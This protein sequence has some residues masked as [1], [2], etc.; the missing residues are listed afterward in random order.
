MYT[1]ACSWRRRLRSLR[2]SNSAGPRRIPG[3]GSLLEWARSTTALH[4][5]RRGSTR[6]TPTDTSRI[7]HSRPLKQHNIALICSGVTRYGVTLGGNWWCHPF[8]LKT[9][10]LFSVIALWK[11][12]TFFSWRLL[13]TPIFPQRLSSVLS[14]SSHKK[15]IISFGCYPLDGV[16]GG[17]LPSP[18]SLVSPLQ[19]C[20]SYNLGLY[21]D[22][23]EIIVSFD[24]FATWSKSVI[25]ATLANDC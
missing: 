9:G 10:D 7:Y 15:N 6:R 24:W 1:Q 22:F 23:D 17:G 25:Y 13:T 5:H 8:F 14:K 18:F 4:R 12:M 3:G 11:V 2:T 16:T 20:N 19:V 21:G